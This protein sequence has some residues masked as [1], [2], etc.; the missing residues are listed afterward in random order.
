MVWLVGRI[1]HSLIQV[2]E[3]ELTQICDEILELLRTECL[4]AGGLD[5]E[6]EVFY[7]KM[8]GDYFRYKAEY[9]T[10]QGKVDTQDEAKGAYKKAMEAAKALQTTSPIRLGLALNFSVFHY[11]ILQKS[12]EACNLAKKAFDDAVGDLEGLDEEQYKDATLIMQLLRDNLTLWD[13]ENRG[14]RYVREEDMDM[15]EFE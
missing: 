7:Y 2:V 3:E 4:T 8:R 5:P 1:T 9:A 13:D 6:E 12:E 14:D 10:G 11:E 15:Q